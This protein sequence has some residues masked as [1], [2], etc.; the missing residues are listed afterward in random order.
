MGFQ[1]E[2]EFFSPQSQAEGVGC[3]GSI[4]GVFGLSC[5]ILSGVMWCDVRLKKE[6]DAIACHQAVEGYWSHSSIHFPLSPLPPHP[7]L[8]S[9]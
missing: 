7:S 6:G 4:A 2:K 8:S 3:K 9:P 1:K 5:Q